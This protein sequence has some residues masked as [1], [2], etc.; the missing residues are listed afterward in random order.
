MSNIA[1]YT[2]GNKM[3]AIFGCILMLMLSSYSLDAVSASDRDKREIA[4]AE[5]AIFWSLVASSGERNRNECAKNLFACSDDRADLGLALLGSKLSIEANEALIF[6][7]RYRLDGGI[8]SN[9]ICFVLSKKSI[10]KKI[11]VRVKPSAL[12]E[13]CVAKRAKII[14]DHPDLMSDVDR[15]AICAE[16]E[17]IDAKR[18]QLLAYI[19]KGEACANSD[20]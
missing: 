18:N 2:W 10:G 19:N 4:M 14:G 5:D 12:R 1:H 15:N 20:F 7:I 16:A 17:E 8:A 6:L 3:K 13:R 9:F 11:L